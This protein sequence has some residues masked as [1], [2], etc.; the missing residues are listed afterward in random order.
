[1]YP[2]E[3][4]PSLGEHG[5]ERPRRSCFGCLFTG[6]LGCGAF[7]C[8]VVLAAALFAPSILGGFVG[9][10]IEGWASSQLNGSIQIRDLQLSWNEIQRANGVQ[11]FDADGAL[12]AEGD[13]RLPSFLA[14]L[15]EDRRWEVELGVDRADV[16]IG[17]DG[18]SNLARALGSDGEPYRA[19]VRG[20]RL[21]AFDSAR[22]FDQVFPYTLEVNGGRVRVSDERRPG[23][24]ATFEAIDCTLTRARARAPELA[25]ECRVLSAERAGTLALEG[26]GF[27]PGARLPGPER[28]SLTGKQL[29]TVLL[30]ALLGVDGRATLALG[31]HFDLGV[32]VDGDVAQGAPL[33]AHL[34]GAAGARLDV[35]GTLRPGHLES[36]DGAGIGGRFVVPRALCEAPCGELLPAGLGVVRAAQ[37]GEWELTVA[38]LD[39][40]LGWGTDA[41]FSLGRLL[42]GAL[43]VGTVRPAGEFRIVDE[44]GAELVAARDLELA[45]A[46][47]PDAPAA[48]E[49]SA[50]V[51]HP[52]PD[53]RL[54][55]DLTAFVR[56][57]RGLLALVREGRSAATVSVGAR[58]LPTL[59]VDRVIDGAG[60]V[61]ALFGDV[62]ELSLGNP[63]G[64]RPGEVWLDL[65][66]GEQRVLR[67]V[68]LEHGALV[69]DGDEPLTLALPWS[70]VAAQRIVAPLLPWLSDVSMPAGG[71][72]TLQIDQLRLPL[73]TGW[74]GAEGVLELGLGRVRYRL[75]AG[76]HRIFHD[77]PEDAQA[78]V[79]EQWLLGIR[80]RLAGGV[81]HYEELTLPVQD[82]EIDLLGQYDMTSGTLDL[83]ADVPVV[84]V[85]HRVGFAKSARP[86]LE[87]AGLSTEISVRGAWDEPRILIDGDAV[88]GF[89]QGG[90]QDL[91]RRANLPSEEALKLL[92]P[93][94]SDG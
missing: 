83:A 86:L 84:L 17:A 21:G 11:L 66:A 40:P 87:L 77:L 49:L 90:L 24:D 5:G 6:T 51:V 44:E 18:V 15:D 35:A 94:T 59:L 71:M 73:D 64:A 13:V 85:L 91:L 47:G 75:H 48:L 80:M 23:L 2:S 89:L 70:D 79:A 92:L 9:K 41:P 72:F 32:E 22:A 25:L 81:V 36:T 37:D 78:P 8:G 57:E 68:R 20:L 1:M 63:A 12:I 4:N 29:P 27:G 74:A 30:D 52:G 76:L 42:D 46:L 56:V 50:D 28:W 16:H 61:P 19:G 55:A 10:G 34:A 62:V 58:A 93:T 69:H 33:D 60:L 26:A 43:L 53:A 54:P 39:V 3:A 38:Q 14:M 82:E 88:R 31:E 67:G 7:L 45:L 65:S